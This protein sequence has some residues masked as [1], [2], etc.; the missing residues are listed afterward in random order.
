MI[1]NMISHCMQL[2]ITNCKNN[3]NNNSM[4]NKDMRVNLKVL[5]KSRITH[6]FRTNKVVIQSNWKYKTMKKGML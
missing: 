3:K 4:N 6:Q 5:T 2:K 1:N